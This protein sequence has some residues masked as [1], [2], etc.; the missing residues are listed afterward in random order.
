ML[1]MRSMSVTLSVGRGTFTSAVSSEGQYESRSIWQ[2]QSSFMRA[3]LW[4][5]NVS[6]LRHLPHKFVRQN[7]NCM[8]V[9]G[10]TVTC[11]TRAQILSYVPSIL[12]C[13][14]RVVSYSGWFELMEDYTLQLSRSLLLAPESKFP[15]MSEDSFL[16]CYVFAPC[17]LMEIINHL[18][19]QIVNSNSTLICDQKIYI[20]VVSLITGLE[21]GAWNGL[22]S[23]M[24]DGIFRKH[25]KAFFH[26]NSQL[27]YLLI[28]RLTAL[29][30]PA[31]VLLPQSH[32]VK[33]DIHIDKLVICVSFVT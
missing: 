22:W 5:Y 8:S 31:F 33:R 17:I 15:S 6:V 28:N 16:T 27:W 11:Y 26:S 4:G 12:K 2:R 3:A 10:Q 19:H 21:Y 23:G 29:Y 30:W 24:D 18:F 13:M 9:G 7:V 20:D 25:L 1:R 14:L 32:R